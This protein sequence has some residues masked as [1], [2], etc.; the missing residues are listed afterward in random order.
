MSQVLWAGF[1]QV[2]REEERSTISKCYYKAATAALAS[3]LTFQSF[4][5]ATAVDETLEM[6]RSFMVFHKS[7]IFALVTLAGSSALSVWQQISFPIEG[8]QT[9]PGEETGATRIY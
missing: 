8:H 5:L 3:H 2:W 6:I 9:S 1:Q 4:S 7:N